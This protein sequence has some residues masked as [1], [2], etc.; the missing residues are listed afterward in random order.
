MPLKVKVYIYLRRIASD[1]ADFKR[2]FTVVKPI[3]GT[4]YDIA[5][6]AGYEAGDDEG[7]NKGHDDGW[8]DRCVD[9]GDW[10]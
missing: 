10:D 5:Y 3:Y 2:I 9:S 1:E 4:V 7:Y 8:Y 6:D